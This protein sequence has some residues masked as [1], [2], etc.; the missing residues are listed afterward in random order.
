MECSKMH[1]AAFGL[2]M[3]VSIALGV[4]VADKYLEKCY[5]RKLQG[6]G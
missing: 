1:W 5:Q 6:N 4:I 3:V 2:L